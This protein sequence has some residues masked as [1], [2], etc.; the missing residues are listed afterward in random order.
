MRRLVALA[1]IAGL[2]ALVLVFGLFALHHNPQVIPAPPWH[3]RPQRPP[4]RP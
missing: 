2:A 1:P 3:D 4:A